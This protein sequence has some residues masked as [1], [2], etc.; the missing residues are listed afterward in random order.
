MLEI[1]C[2]A[3]SVLPV[4]QTRLFLCEVE[5]PLVHDAHR[6]NTFFLIPMLTLTRTN[7][8]LLPFSASNHPSIH[9]SIHPNRTGSGWA[10]DHRQSG[11]H[12]AA[13]G[14]GLHWCERDLIAQ[15]L[16]LRVWSWRNEEGTVGEREQCE[17]GVGSNCNDLECTWVGRFVWG[18]HYVFGLA[19]LG[20]RFEQNL[21][22]AQVIIV[23]E[24]TSSLRAMNITK[25]NGQRKIAQG[26]VE[27]RQPGP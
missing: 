1:I 5:A 27:Y 8:H 23:F 24:Y 21:S 15:R 16:V 17:A 26:W 2:T 25:A 20:S 10:D 6:T 9:P 3:T 18:H 12:T 4:V 13:D 22:H 11:V 14:L 7:L 19:F